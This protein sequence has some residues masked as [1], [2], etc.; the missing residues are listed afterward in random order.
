MKIVVYICNSGC[1][2]SKV[3]DIYNVTKDYIS[4]KRRSF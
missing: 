4:N 2:Q 1:I 3:R